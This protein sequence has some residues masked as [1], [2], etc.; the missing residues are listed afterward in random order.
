MAFFETLHLSA[1]IVTHLTAPAV[2]G[3]A[4]LVSPLTDE[5]LQPERRFWQTILERYAI[6]AI[7]ILLFFLSLIL[8]IDKKK[9][10]FKQVA[11]SL[12]ET[13]PTRSLFGWSFLL[14]TITVFI[15]WA[16]TRLTPVGALDKSWFATQFE[17]QGY[18]LILLGLLLF[19]FCLTL[20]R[21]RIRKRLALLNLCEPLPL[22]SWWPIP[23]LILAYPLCA[24]RQ[25]GFDGVFAEQIPLALSAIFVCWILWLLRGIAIEG[26]TSRITQELVARYTGFLLILPTLLAVVSM[27]FLKEMSERKW[28]Q[29]DHLNSTNE[30][31]YGLNSLE[32]EVT[33]ALFERQKNF[34]QKLSEIQSQ[35]LPNSP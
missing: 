16:W 22:L 18:H 11:A 7:A 5:D 33:L 24:L 17:P 19:T 15:H 21:Y 13:I 10:P 20:A 2:S 26:R 9:K 23:F 4:T 35:A 29:S 34:H 8:L 12:W 28:F 27:P 25:L 6:F 14:T 1:G 30:S 3:Y 31:P 32:S